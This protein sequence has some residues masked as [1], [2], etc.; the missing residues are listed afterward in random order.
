MSDARRTAGEASK[1]RRTPSSAPQKV[2]EPTGAGLGTFGG[3]FTPSILTILGVIMYL[4]FGWVVGQAGLVG[5]WAIVSIST[6]ITL[7]TALSISQISSDQ[8]VRAGGAYYMISRS[9]GIEIGGAVGIPLYLAQALSVALY[10]IGFAES[11]NQIFSWADIRVVAGI[12]TVLVTG[13]AL[14][15]ARAA[16]RA[17]YVIMAAIALSLVSFFLG[18]AAEPVAAAAEANTNVSFWVVLAVFFPAVTGIMAGVNMSGDL[19]DARRSIPRG[20]LAAVGVSYALYM[21]I[22][23]VL[24]AR[25]TVPDLIADPLIMRRV[26]LVG[27]AILVGVWGATLSSALGSILGAPR[28]LQALAREGVLPRFMRAVGRGQGS[29]DDPRIATYITMVLALGAVML[30][31]LDVIAP[32][33]T[34]FFLTT[35]AVVNLVSAIERFLRSPSFRPTFRVH[36][37]LSLLGAI[38]C[39]ALMLLINPPATVAAVVV[40]VGVYV[41]MQQRQLR[42]AWGD[43]RQGL[44][45]AMVRWGILQLREESD[46]RN[47][48]PHLLV[49]SGTPSRRW[50]LIELA[51]ALAH[52]R[53]LLSVAAVVPAESTTPD[54]KVSMARTIRDYLE[55][56]SVEALVRVTRASDVYTGAADLVE[57]YGIGP[58]VPNTVLMGDSESADDIGAYCRLLESI[59]EARR[60][61][62]V[63]KAADPEDAFGERRRIDIWWQ[64]KKGNGALMVTLAYLLLT[65]IEWSDA[66]VSLKMIAPNPDAQAEMKQ[67]LDGMIEA[68][69]MGFKTEVV[70]DDRPAAEAIADRSRG[71]DLV[72]LGMARPDEVDDFTGY[73]Q[74]LGER[75]AALPTVAF[76]LA[77]ELVEFGEILD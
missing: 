9:L 7:L 60:N 6:A 23:A 53:T 69:R 68:S 26:S 77:S 30:G 37:S 46:A 63:I 49:L 11:V 36:W 40:V 38:G 65:G 54:R 74:Q 1:R 34:M 19:A 27:D 64:G 44:W 24:I 4:R 17:Q 43:V 42:T 41:W 25:A 72:M 56:R 48:R 12:T 39:G 20:T 3:V 29:Q 70:L 14:V 28:I 18:S 10:T 8:R 59:Y 35:Y 31:S 21:V 16:I 66:T 61:V 76:V 62:V 5:T 47:W 32:I 2:V 51:N 45:Y 55:E 58:L 52:N 73:Y 57:A 22:P 67:N 15:S 75:F 33:L 50:Y 71:A 13:V